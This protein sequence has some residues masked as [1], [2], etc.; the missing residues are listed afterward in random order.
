[1]QNVVP[2]I[3]LARPADYAAMYAIYRPYVLETAVSFETAEPGLDEFCRRIEKLTERYPCLLAEQ[4][5]RIV[6][7]AYANTFNARAAYDW[8]AESTIYLDRDCRRRGIGRKLYAV[9]EKMLAAQGVCSLNACIGV[10]RAEKDP[11]LTRDS[12][13]FHERMGF[14]MVGQFDCCGNKFGRWYDMAWMEKHI[15]AHPD[16]PRPV[17]WFPQIRERFQNYEA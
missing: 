10:P 17:Q 12:V 2:H 13:N 6:G 9:L 1:M 4:E 14:R 8:S 11:Y 5:G 7:Y 15:A 3:R 16:C